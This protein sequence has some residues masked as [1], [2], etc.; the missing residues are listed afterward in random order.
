MAPTALFSK[1][2]IFATS[3][4]TGEVVRERWLSKSIWRLAGARPSGRKSLFQR[5]IQRRDALPQVRNHCRDHHLSWSQGTSASPEPLNNAYQVIQTPLYPALPRST[6]LGGLLYRRFAEDQAGWKTCAIRI[7]TGHLL[8]ERPFVE[9]FPIH[10]RLTPA[11]ASKARPMGVPVT[12]VGT[13]A[14]TPKNR[15][16][17]K[18]VLRLSCRNRR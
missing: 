16:L 15:A 3:F 18:A 7:A 4:R 2:Q 14:T 10:D 12:D 5:D 17:S 13:A 8:D 6:T 1:H 9:V 11:Q